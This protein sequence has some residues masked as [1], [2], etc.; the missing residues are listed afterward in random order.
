M[1]LYV[2]LAFLSALLF[3]AATPISKVLLE[4]LSPFQLA[5]LLYLGA[6]IGVLPMLVLKGKLLPVWKVYR[7]NQVRLVGAVLLGGIGGPVALLFGLQLAAAASVAMWLNLEFVATALL[8]QFVFKDYL[9]KYGWLAAGGTVLAAGLLSWGEGEAGLVA[10][11]MVALGCLCWGFDNHL[12][13][14]IDGI[15]PSESTFWKGSVAGTVNLLIGLQL[16]PLAADWI[17]TGE[18]LALGTLSYGA[19][20]ALYIT[21]AQHIGA[22]RGQMIFSTAPFFGVALS[23]AILGEPLTVL[24]GVAAG[25]L[26]GALFLLA[27]EGHG[28]EHEHW[29]MQHEHWHRHD[30]EHH[31][32]V[33]PKLPP[34][35]GH[36]H[37]HEHEG[38]AH[39]HPHMPDLHHR[40]RHD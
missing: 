8:G 11:L 38:T 23:I 9:G 18:A 12:T 5:G 21:A 24:Q 31:M 28:H 27:R 32:H 7:K 16:A 37:A 33:H 3:G 2:I 26:V 40:H 14:L 36:S 29:A 20:I 25:V 35:F 34:W 1:I 15:T 19:S 10:G 17:V 6:A 39:A 22:T 13:A 30:D 4:D